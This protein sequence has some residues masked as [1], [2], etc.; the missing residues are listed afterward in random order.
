[1]NG[2]APKSNVGPSH[3]DLHVR[4]SEGQGPAHISTAYWP[5]LPS[6]SFL[7][8][9]QYSNGC[10]HSRSLRPILPVVSIHI[11]NT[12]KEE[13][14]KISCGALWTWREVLLVLELWVLEHSSN[15]LPHH[16][17]RDVSSEVDY[18]HSRR[19]PLVISS[20]VVASILIK[21]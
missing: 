18:S 11:Q 9:C 21:P 6:R 14:P 12:V 2:T 3:N 13:E 16:P 4:S 20:K 7:L 8:P 19:I 5:T 17:D 15:L 10:H 1:M